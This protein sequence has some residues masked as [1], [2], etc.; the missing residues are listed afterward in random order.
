MAIEGLLPPRVPQGDGPDLPGTPVSPD[1]L[2]VPDPMS[3]AAGAKGLGSGMRLGRGLGVG[4]ISELSPG[5]GR[6]VGKRG[7]GPQ[8][9][10]PG[11]GCPAGVLGQGSR[12]EARGTGRHPGLGGRAWVGSGSAAHRLCD[13]GEVTGPLWSL[14]A[15]SSAQWR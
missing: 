8:G 2:R 11:W 3:G 7:W 9:T 14:S 13:L 10:R 12:D 6:L 1:I 4:S 15:A 5:W